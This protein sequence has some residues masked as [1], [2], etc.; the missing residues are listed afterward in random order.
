MEIKKHLSN[1]FSDL[2]D[3]G[4]EF[5]IPFR[6]FVHWNLSKLV[7]FVYSFAAG[8]VFSVPFLLAMG[9]IGYYALAFP[10]GDATS[11][12]VSSR[13]TLSVSL[14]QL[15]LLENLGKVVVELL[16]FVCVL[17]VFS[18]FVTYGYY[19]LANVYRSYLEGTELPVRTNAYFDRKRLYKFTAALGWSSLYVLTPVVVGLVAFAVAVIFLSS[20]DAADESRNLVLGSVTAA[21]AA[22]SFFA[23]LYFAIRT[24]FSTFEILSDDSASETGRAY[25]RRSMALT[26]GKTFRIVMLVLPFAIVTGF[27]ESLIR[28]ADYAAAVSRMY[29]EAV[30]LKAETGTGMDDTA[31]LEGYLD[32]TLDVAD[33]NDVVSIMGGHQARKEGIDREFFEEVAPYLDRSELDPDAGGFESLFNL[34]S[35]LLLDGLLSMA[36]LS[37][38]LR[39]GGSLRGNA[40]TATTGAETPEAPTEEPVAEEPKKPVEKPAAKPKA[41]PKNKEADGKPKVPA[42]KKPAAKKGTAE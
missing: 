16:L 39:L 33:Q 28:N 17:T 1:Y 18:I 29:S 32:R 37:I 31:F 36:Y 34:L 2:R 15:A 9:A 25:V 8:L 5:A 23:F 27:A 3:T 11:A 20:P 13:Q 7:I 24:G 12:L 21:I 35:F 14:I 19:L 4:K 40:P 22:A 30:R 38:F 26:K 42:K 41:A 6:H 10:A